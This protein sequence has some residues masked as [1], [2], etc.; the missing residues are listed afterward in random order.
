MFTYAVPK[1]VE[2]TEVIFLNS[3]KWQSFLDCLPI[4]T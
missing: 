3:E 1:D 2:L 4:L